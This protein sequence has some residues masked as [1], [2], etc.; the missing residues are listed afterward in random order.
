MF[1]EVD[2]NKTIRK[3]NDL[4]DNYDRLKRMSLYDG[5]LTANYRY[6]PEKKTQSSSGGGIGKVIDRRERGR[7]IINEIDNAIELVD[8]EYQKLLKAKYF[9]KRL[10]F[11]IY[12]SLS[13]SK[14][15]YYKKLRRAKLQFAEAYKAGELLC[16]A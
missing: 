2:E 10:D 7:E 1:P 5:N 4:L 6:S 13:I 3:V 8:Q 11:D 12:S 15:G 9:S 14:S 16:F